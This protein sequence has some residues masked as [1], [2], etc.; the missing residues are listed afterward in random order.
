MAHKFRY[1]DIITAVCWNGYNLDEVKKVFPNYEVT[2]TSGHL[3]RCNGFAGCVYAHPGNWIVRIPK[4]S[5]RCIDT[6]T[7]SLLF[8]SVED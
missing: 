4:K 8:E 7:F 5:L 3:C 1:K 2:L 6:L